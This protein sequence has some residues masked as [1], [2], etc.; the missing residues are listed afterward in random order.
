VV[1]RGVRKQERDGV[2]VRHFV[3]GISPLSAAPDQAAVIEALRAISAAW[4]HEHAGGENGFCMGRF[5]PSRLDQA[6]LSVAWRPATQR[7]EAFVTWV[8]IPARRGW[9]L[10]LMRRR[11]EAANGIMELLIVNS[12]DAARERGDAILSL[13]LSALAKVERTTSGDA[14]VAAAPD[15]ART[16]LLERLARFYD[17]QG[18]FNW[19]RKFTST[20]EERYLIFP[21]PLALP[22]IALALVRAQTPEGLLTFL[23][24]RTAPKPEPPAQP[25]ERA[26]A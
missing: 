14:A 10:D 16:F 24:S 23:R 18:L 26:P 19:K 17:F 21:D 1:R 25:L 2:Q 6:W 11:P 12:V 3:P 20:F 9:V 22:Q 4:L 13:G 5:Q 15:P 8:P 7:I